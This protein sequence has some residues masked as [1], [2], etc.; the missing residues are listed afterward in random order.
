MQ[1][2]ATEALLL[3]SLRRRETHVRRSA[4]LFV[5]VRD[6]AKNVVCNLVKTKITI[7]TDVNQGEMGRLPRTKDLQK[8]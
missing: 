6:D 3:P 8:R 7:F 4:L 2:V 1:R 5:H